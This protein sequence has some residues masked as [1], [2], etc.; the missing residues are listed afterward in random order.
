MMNLNFTCP[1]CCGHIIEEV[2][3]NVTV[4]SEITEVTMDDGNHL[5]FGYCDQI[6]EGGEVDRYQCSN[7][8]YTVAEGGRVQVREA[9]EKGGWLENEPEDAD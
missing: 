5:E 8:G 6:N 9:L 1:R 7:C 3:V 2:M 4:V